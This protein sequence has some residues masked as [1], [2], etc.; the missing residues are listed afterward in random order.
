M[1]V[2]NFD[3]SRKDSMSTSITLRMSAVFASVLFISSLCYYF[4]LKNSLVETLRANGVSDA[5]LEQQ[6]INNVGTSTFIT[7]I[8]SFIL[9][10]I[11]IFVVWRVI[12]KMA[13]LL[14]NFR[15]HY[16]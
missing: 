16:E 15:I 2:V 9:G 4:I 11:G 5:N 14:N 12:L 7:L 3:F 8:V 13:T 6:L 10:G 1:G